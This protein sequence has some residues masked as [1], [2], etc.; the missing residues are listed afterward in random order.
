MPWNW[1]FNIYNRTNI[2]H[3]YKFEAKQPW[4]EFYIRQDAAG[5]IGDGSAYT[6][7]GASFAFN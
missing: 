3:E 6:E 1:S 5:L 4:G 7:L 2:L